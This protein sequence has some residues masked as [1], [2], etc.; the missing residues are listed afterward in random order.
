M[1]KRDIHAELVEGFDALKDLRESIEAS[2]DA[3]E[4]FCLRVSTD[5]E[6]DRSTWTYQDIDAETTYRA[7][8]AGAAWSAKRIAN[9]VKERP[10]TDEKGS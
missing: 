5:P 1:T 2:K 7:F 10:C 8:C 9:A 4:K 6:P 3:F